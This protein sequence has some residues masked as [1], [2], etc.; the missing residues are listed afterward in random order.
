MIALSE[1]KELVLKMCGLQNGSDEIKK[2]LAGWSGVVQYRLDG[3]EFY[4][5][6]KA[7]G[8]C[9]FKEGVHDS[10]TFTVIASP[11]Y[12]LSVLKG[13]EDP[14]MGFM[15]QKYRIEGNIIQAQKLAS[16]LKKFA[17]KL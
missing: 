6:Y 10:P 1:A 15:M 2:E 4:V 11:D 3:E 9:E 17:G 7:D 5:E 16:I 14:I 13:Q 8:S 12:W